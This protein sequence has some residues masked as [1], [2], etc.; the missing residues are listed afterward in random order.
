MKKYDL[1]LATHNKDKIRELTRLIDGNFR[2]VGIDQFSSEDVEE[3]GTTLWDN[4]LIKAQA[5]FDVSGIPS[6]ADDTGLEVDALDGAPGV[7][8]SR[9]AGENATYADNVR[10][11]LADLE[12]IEPERRTA[13]FR[14]VVA[15]VD[16]ERT[17]R[18]DGALE[19]VILEKARG[20]SG[21][22][23]DPVFLP[24]GGIKTLAEL[25]LTEKNKISHRGKAFSA[26]VSW[27]LKHGRERNHE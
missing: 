19:G 15:F 9:F 5:G 21:F 14:T 16:G 23:Y 1:V 27:W 4:A 8:S 26:F 11:L 24:T 18:F 12:G 25:P 13:R 7:Y 17:M 3:T 20:E 6:V 10:K 22:G 2:V